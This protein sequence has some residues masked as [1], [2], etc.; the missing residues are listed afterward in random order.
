[1]SVKSSKQE[2]GRRWRC[3]G[4]RRRTDYVSTRKKAQPRDSVAIVAS[5]PVLGVI[6]F[7]GCQS[8]IEKARIEMDPA[9]RSA[10]LLREQLKAGVTL[11][12]FNRLRANFAAELSIISDRMRAKPSTEKLLQP[13]FAAYSSALDA[14]S[15]VGAVWEARSAMDACTGPDPDPD[16]ASAQSRELRSRMS[17]DEEIAAINAESEWL[18]RFAKCLVE[19]DNRRQALDQRS[20]E[21]N[22]QCPKGVYSHLDCTIE[23]AE[24]KLTAADKLLMR[25]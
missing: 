3:I 24:G 7:L 8:S 14:Y 9:Y 12:E 20:K 1:M 4:F 18:V 11:V 23:N 15:L 2:P 6:L 17:S 22:T 25:R 10:R 19:G 5:F 21:L 16:Y 13:Y